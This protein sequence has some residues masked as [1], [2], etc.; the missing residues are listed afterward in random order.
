MILAA[1]GRT[2]FAV[3]WYGP[4]PTSLWHRI[5]VLKERNKERNEDRERA[6]AYRPGSLAAPSLRKESHRRKRNGHR[7]IYPRS[8][9][10]LRL[11]TL[12]EKERVE[13]LVEGKNALPGDLW[14]DEV[15]A[16]KIDVN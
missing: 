2:N 1:V 5:H 16:T 7:I 4:G 15:A 12:A 3:T 11:P 13:G 14:L 10:L 8:V 6:R 9:Y